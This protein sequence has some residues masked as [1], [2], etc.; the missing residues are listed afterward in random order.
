MIIAGSS[1]QAAFCN[2]ILFARMIVASPAS[3]H[4]SQAVQAV[5]AAEQAM[6]GAAD[7]DRIWR[8]MNN[9]IDRNGI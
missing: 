5:E 3:P 6:P 8:I 4:S 9:M 1:D 2:C 7:A